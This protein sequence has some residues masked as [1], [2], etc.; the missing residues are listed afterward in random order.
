MTTVVTIM[1]LLTTIAAAAVTGGAYTI[2]FTKASDE[3]VIVTSGFSSTGASAGTWMKISAFKSYLL[4]S[5][6]GGETL[7]ALARQ[8]PGPTQAQRSVQASSRQDT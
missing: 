1:A 6:A 8:A 2:R 3:E 5:S 4:S 7:R